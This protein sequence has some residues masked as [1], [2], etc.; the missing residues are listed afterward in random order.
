MVKRR[1]ALP[2][3][4]LN[5]CVAQRLGAAPTRSRGHRPSWPPAPQRAR[6]WRPSGD[7][8][9]LAKRQGRRRTSAVSWAGMVSCQA[10]LSAGTQTDSHWILL[11]CCA[12]LGPSWATS[13]ASADALQRSHKVV[14]VGGWRTAA[15]AALRR[16]LAPIPSDAIWLQSKT[17]GLRWVPLQVNGAAR[18]NAQG[19]GRCGSSGCAV[20]IVA[21]TWGNGSSSHR[22]RYS[23][24]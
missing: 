18:E 21:V 12:S 2:V 19:S 7:R 9:A 24:I 1:R 17:P 3:D 22:M 13:A 23:R 8:V 6:R 14:C 20:A 16:L 4:T 15:L 11:E 5:F 10:Y